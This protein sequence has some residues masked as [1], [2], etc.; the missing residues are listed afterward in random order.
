MNRFFRDA[1]VTGI[2]F[3]TVNSSPYA[4]EFYHKMGFVNLSDE[5]EKDGIRFTPMRMELR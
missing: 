4:V 5:I 3:V 2:T 1:R